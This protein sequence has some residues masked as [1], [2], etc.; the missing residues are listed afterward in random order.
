MLRLTLTVDKGR[1]V[2]TEYE[3]QDVLAN[4]LIPKKLYYN[5]LNSTTNFS[6]GFVFMQILYHRKISYANFVQ[7]GTKSV[8]GGTL[9]DL[10]NISTN[11]KASLFQ[12]RHLT[13]I[14]QGETRDMSDQEAELPLF[15]LQNTLKEFNRVVEFTPFFKTGDNYMHS[16]HDNQFVQLTLEL[17]SEK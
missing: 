14:Y 16:G 1:F 12:T 3:L 10:K 4:P 8:I 5:V 9:Y 13:T 7:D 11:Q 6:G 15:M 2:A 17:Y